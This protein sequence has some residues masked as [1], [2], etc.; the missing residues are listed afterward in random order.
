MK[1]RKQC[2]YKRFEAKLSSCID[3]DEKFANDE[4]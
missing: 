1:P 2:S 3:A 4:N